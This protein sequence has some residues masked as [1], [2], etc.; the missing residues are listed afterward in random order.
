MFWLTYKRAIIR[1]LDTNGNYTC[2]TP[3][4]VLVLFAARS[5]FVYHTIYIYIYA[6]I[7]VHIIHDELKI[8]WY[9]INVYNSNQL[10]MKRIFVVIIITKA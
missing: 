8:I 6:N 10:K 7:H 3:Y 5:Q 1:Q 9:K 2:V 4:L